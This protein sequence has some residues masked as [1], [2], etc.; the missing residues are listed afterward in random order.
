MADA[1]ERLPR[2]LGLLSAVGLVIGITIGSGIF[3]TPAVIAGRVPDPMLML[4]VWVIGGLL[5]LCG[6][7]SI[8]ELAAAYP[9]TGGLYVYL[10]EG[11][12]RLV[13]FLFGWAQLVLV[14]ASALGGI[15]SVFG[16]YALRSLGIDPAQHPQAS[17]LVAAGVII[18]AMVMNILGVQVGAAIVG[19]STIAKYGAL[20][21]LVVLSFALGGGRGG[22]MGHFTASGGEVEAGLFGLALISVL[23]A[24]DGFADLSYVAGE[25]RDPGRNMPRALI[26]GTAGI[27]TIYIAANLAYLYIQPV[28][29]MA[30][31][32]LVA[33]DTLM[34]L[35]GG[36]GV[37]LI[38]IVVMISTFGSV[39]GSMLVNPRIFFAMAEDRLFFQ[40]MARVHSRYQTPH[41][42]I[43]LTAAL[44]V[45]FVLTRTFEQL[46]DTFVLTMWPFYGLSVAAVYRLRRL[47]PDLARPYRVSGYPVVPALFIAGATYLIVNALITEPLWTSVT[48]AIVL[49]GIPVYLIFFRSDRPRDRGSRVGA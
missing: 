48:F 18:F 37:T 4:G 11:W 36:I 45:F 43:L 3:R 20:V 21:V 33:A 25:V 34:A 31:S 5:A 23:W 17:N 10:R 22:S 13:A 42:A 8:A 38:S 7:L 49:A 2:R 41:V 6:A 26:A 29:S 39:N 14:R 24:Y 32:P 35:V 12:G 1:R 40:S 28:E 46:A 19:A 27:I 15:A 9:S 30:Q 16:A 47:R 44:G